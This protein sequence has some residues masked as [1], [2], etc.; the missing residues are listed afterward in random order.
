MITS[1]ERKELIVS[2]RDYVDVFTWSYDDMPD[3][4]TDIVVYRVPLV[5]GCKP[6]KQK[7]RRTHPEVLIKVN[8]KIK[9]QWNAGFLEVV[10]YPQWVSNI[11]VARRTI[12][13]CHT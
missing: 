13:H 6:F 3:L 4:D 10:K 7:L 12:F 8:A 5:E 2:L 9:K 1:K 11:V